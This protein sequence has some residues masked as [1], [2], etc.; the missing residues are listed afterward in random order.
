M[1]RNS[2]FI[3]ATLLSLAFFGLMS[4]LDFLAAQRKL[5]F[6]HCGPSIALYFGTLGLN[7]FATALALNRKFLLKDTGR[8]LSHF[9]KQMQS[10]AT[11]GVPSF[12]EEQP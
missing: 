8:K 4:R 11:E 12:I 1:I 10:G 9:D 6:L 7:L 5:L 3:A 2:L